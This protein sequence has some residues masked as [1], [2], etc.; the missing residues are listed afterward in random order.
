[1]SAS[2][3][4]DKPDQELVSLRQ[5][6]KRLPAQELDR[7]LGEVSNDIQF[8]EDQIRFDIESYDTDELEQAYAKIAHI[9]QRAEILKTEL[10]R[11]NQF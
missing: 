10:N 11:R 6:V 7:D 2:E 4:D 1:M 8:L 5:R 3:P 9:K